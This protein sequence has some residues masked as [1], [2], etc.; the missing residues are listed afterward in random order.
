M[1]VNPLETCDTILGI[2]SS[3]LAV[4]AGIFAWVWQIW[5]QVD[6]TL[7]ITYKIPH[8]WCCPGFFL[9]LKSIR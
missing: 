6:R 1:R 3:I 8:D 9:M 2:Y 4:A 7:C 5:S